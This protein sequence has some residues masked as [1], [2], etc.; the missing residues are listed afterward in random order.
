MIVLAQLAALLGATTAHLD[1]YERDS[2]ESY[3]FGVAFAALLFLGGHLADRV[4]GRR[5]LVIGLSGLAAAAVLGGTGGADYPAVLITARALQGGFGALV[6]AAALALVTTAFPEPKERRKAFGVYAT[7]SLGGPVLQ[8]VTTGSTGLGVDLAVVTVLA[9]IALAATR[10]LPHDLTD[11]LDRTGTRFDVPGVLL[12]ALGVAALGYGFANASPN[13]N[14]AL[15]VGPLVVGLLLCAA[16]LWRQS[17]ASNPLLPSYVLKERNRLGGFLTMVLAGAG[18]LALVPALARI[19]MWSLDHSV[20][21][22]GLAML[23]MVAAIAISASLIAPRLLNRSVAPRVLIVAGLVITP[24]GVAL[25]IVGIESGVGRMGLQLSMTLAGLGAGLAFMPIFATVTAAG[26]AT[27]L[28]RHSG[29]ASAA[30]LTAQAVGGGLGAAL[31]GSVGAPPWWA[32]LCTLLAALIAGLM[33]T[34]RDLVPTGVQL[35]PNH[36]P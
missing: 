17:V 2:P 34:G 7:V 14:N 11:R 23:P 13:W 9:L 25:G 36:R 20:S 21:G 28:H 1:H 15:V 31:V 27:G 4:G 3:V 33:V 18:V 10:V 35:A 12:S 5:T 16:F 22:A 29:G 32:V 30:L 19:L 8:M 24:L 6:T 26:T